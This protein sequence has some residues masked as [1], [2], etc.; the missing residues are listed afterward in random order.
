MIALVEGT[1]KGEGQIEWGP[2]GTTSTGTFSTV[3]MNLAAPFGPGS[4]PEVQRACVPRERRASLADGRVDGADSV[5]KEGA[6]ADGRVHAAGGVAKKGERPVGR[7][8][9]AGGIV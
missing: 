5:I 9:F 1:V 2:G 3:G 4:A 6:V 8:R 7:V